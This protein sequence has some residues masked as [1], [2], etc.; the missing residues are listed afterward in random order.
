MFLSDDPA[1]P[2]RDHVLD[3]P[4]MAR[5]FEA[6]LADGR[7]VSIHGGRPEI[8]VYRHG[9]RVSA[10]YRL[11]VGGDEHRV[12]LRTYP[13][14]EALHAATAGEPS[15]VRGLRAVAADDELRCAYWTFPNDARVD[16]AAAMLPPRPGWHSELVRYVPERAAIACWRDAGGRPVAFAKATADA[17]AE[18]VAVH[19]ALQAR[20][21]A[22][23]EL[24][25][26]PRVL[27]WSRDTR[28][29]VTEAAPGP[30]LDALRG[31]SRADGLRALG[32][33]LARLHGLEPPAW[34][35]PGEMVPRRLD[36]VLDAVAAARPDVSPLARALARALRA[37]VPADAGGP[38]WLHR[39]ITVRNALAWRRG[40]ALVDLDDMAVGPAAAD[41]GRVLSWLLTSRVLG[42]MSAREASALRLAL[43]DGYAE[44]RDP[45]PEA[46]LRWQTA[47]ATLEHSG[48]KAVAWLDADIGEHLE[49][50]FG[51]AAG[52]L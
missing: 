22:E 29:L 50:L 36:A 18:V 49:A 24:L 10:V 19:R 9:R 33:G 42:Q 27:A 15:P 52:L 1:V 2:Q 39:D 12:A 13:T 14:V 3:A 30:R 40:V 28:L 46:A 5:R 16:A 44:L 23:D 47:A 8:S 17:P 6:V 45:P 35:T 34:L 26:V 43:L 7:P 48:R 38:A 37:S 11:A 41:F 51:E 31:P 20:L 32:R 25:R 4:T 21:G